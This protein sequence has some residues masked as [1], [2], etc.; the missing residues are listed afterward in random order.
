[1]AMPL[2]DYRCSSCDQIE[3]K[4]HGMNEKPIVNCARCGKMM[5]KMFTRFIPRFVGGGF[6]VND[7]NQHGRNDTDA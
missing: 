7:Y 4:M 5:E 3:E 1:M 6:H 2:Y